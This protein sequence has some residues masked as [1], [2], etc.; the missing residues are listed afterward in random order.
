MPAPKLIGYSSGT[1]IPVGGTAELDNNYPVTVVAIRP[2]IDDE[3]TGIV[4][5]RYSWGSTE[6]VDPS[7]L[8]AYIPA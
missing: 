2:A 6:D 1:A 4:T 8:G 3:D 7:R 5:I